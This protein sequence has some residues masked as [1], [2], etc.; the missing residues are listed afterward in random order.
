M[1]K[2]IEKEDKEKDE[3]DEKMDEKKADDEEEENTFEAHTELEAIKTKLAL[4]SARNCL[5]D[6]CWKSL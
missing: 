5:R 4:A 1:A 3:E 2:E 6:K